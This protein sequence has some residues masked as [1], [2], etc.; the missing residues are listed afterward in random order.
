MNAFSYLIFTLFIIVFSVSTFA[1]TD[2]ELRDELGWAGHGNYVGAAGSFRTSQCDI[3]T[4]TSGVLYGMPSGATVAKAHLIWAA[5]NDTPDYQVT[6]SYPATNTDFIVNAEIDRQ[7][8]EDF[9]YNG[10]THNYYSGA[11]DVTSQV[12]SIIGTANGGNYTFELTG[13]NIQNTNHYCD[14]GQVFGGFS[15]IVVY[16]LASDP[17]RLV[18]VFEGFS[19]FWQNSLTL[20]PKNFQVPSPLPAGTYNRGKHAHIT[21][22]GDNANG[23]DGE[24]LF[25]ENNVLTNTSNDNGNQFNSTFSDDALS[26][27]VHITSGMDGVDFD[28]YDIS[29]SVTAGSTE[30]TT[31]YDAGFD[32]VILSAEVLSIL[33]VNV[34]D[35]EVSE[36]VSANSIT[37]RDT[38]ADIRVNIDNN[39]PFPTAGDLTATV[40]LPA[41]LTLFGATNFSSNG[42]TCAL[43][44]SSPETID[45]AK[46][47]NYSDGQQDYFDISVSVSANAS[48]NLSVDVSIPGTVANPYPIT[49]G[50]FDNVTSNNTQTFNYTL[51]SGDITTS[52]KDYEDVDGG[53]I[54]AGNT[55]KYTITLTETAGYAVTGVSVD[56][57]LVNDLESLIITSIPEGA[58]NSSV[59]ESNLV[60]VSDITVPANS[61]VIIEYTANILSSVS[62]STVITNTATID[63]SDITS[64]DISSDFTVIQLNPLDTVKQLYLR[65]NSTLSRNVTPS[66]ENGAITIDA[67]G[68]LDWTLDP[69][70]VTDFT[71]DQ[72]NLDLVVDRTGGRNTRD[73]DIE[74]ILLDQDDQVI[75]SWSQDDYRLPANPRVR[76]FPLDMDKNQSYSITYD[77][78]LAKTLTL[79]VK[80]NDNNNGFNLTPYSTA[81][82]IS[83][84]QIDTT[85]VINV[86]SVEFYD[87]PHSDNTASISGNL[88][89]QYEPGETI[90]GRIKVSDPFG[91]F[92][93]SDV[94]IQLIDPLN[95]I[96]ITETILTEKSSELITDLSEAQLFYEFEYDLPLDA[97]KGSWQTTVTANEGAE[98]TIWNTSVDNV[99]VIIPPELTVTKDV[100][101]FANPG[102]PITQAQIGDLLQYQ[103]LIENNSAGDAETVSAT[104]NISPYSAF[105][106]TSNNVLDD[107]I[108]CADCAA[109]GLTYVEPTYSADNGTSFTHPV[110]ITQDGNGN[111]LDTNITNFKIDFTGTMLAGESITFTYQV[112]V[113]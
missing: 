5:S 67:G 21:W 80:N 15:L 2:V 54:E 59:P 81:S 91:T 34:A 44:S 90:Y 28:I 9:E 88:V 14:N 60:S 30:V 50:E 71:I 74:F 38:T 92:D 4:T 110:V 1:A 46:N 56:D 39:G 22:E 31:D 102:T 68:F 99:L 93:I 105:V 70:L 23:N 84:V 36:G 94:T 10:D 24:N 66:N 109:A 79:R 53:A 82:R 95:N 43:I 97:E 62:D 13:L 51:Q 113:K 3:T 78:N 6:L 69:K 101:L 17:L 65:D 108:I 27:E 37:A 45:C 48:T 20:T 35:L 103:V 57:T 111:N 18:N 16:E 47:I 8:I 96:L 77:P 25:F 19:K 61:T 11:A 12:Q 76:S 42:F 107:S 33:N 112:V 83:Q 73:V 89:T 55:I 49:G 75:A 87:A 40:I 26:P 98:G 86:N 64:F 32:L 85:T 104:D 100:F 72:V 52:T 29:S 106:F 63:G 58:T 41:D 7:Y